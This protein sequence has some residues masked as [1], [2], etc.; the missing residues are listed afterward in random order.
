[1]IACDDG[2]ASFQRRS[3]R[4]PFPNDL[5]KCDVSSTI[6][7][8]QNDAECVRTIMWYLMCSNP[9]RMG[10]MKNVYVRSCTYTARCNTYVNRVYAVF[11][12][13]Y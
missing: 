10:G 6:C 13:T 7:N 4:I 3:R 5:T 2:L 11:G 8:V 1:M 12:Y 9:E